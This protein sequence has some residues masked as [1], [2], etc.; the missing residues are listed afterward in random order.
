MRTG[1]PIP[2]LKITASERETLERWARGHDRRLASRA[3]A[4]L[5]SA[6]RVSNKEVAARCAMTKQTVGKGRARFR[7][8]RLR[9]LYDEPRPGAPRRI[10]DAQVARVIRLTA[11]R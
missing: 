6:D 9:G 1:R 3:S 8:S 2:P 7:V 11:E 4:I 10:T 5:A